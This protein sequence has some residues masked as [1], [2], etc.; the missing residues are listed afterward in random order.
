MVV[1]APCAW[2]LSVSLREPKGRI[3]AGEL[4]PLWSFSRGDRNFGSLKMNFFPATASVSSLVP[5]RESPLLAQELPAAVGDRTGVRSRVSGTRPR[6]PPEPNSP[7]G[8]EHPALRRSRGSGAGIPCGHGRAAA[9]APISAPR[10]PPLPLPVLP[11]GPGAA[12]GRAAAALGP[13]CGAGGG[14]QPGGCLPGR[15]EPGQVSPRRRAEPSCAAGLAVAPRSPGRG[16]CAGARGGRRRWAPCCWARC[17]WRLPAAPRVSA[18]PGDPALCWGT[19]GGPKR[20]DPLGRV[21]GAGPTPAGAAGAARP[22]LMAWPRLSAECLRGNGA[23]YRGN[24]RVASGGAPCLNW[25]AVRSGPGAALPAG[26]SGGRGGSGG[27]G[28][29]RRG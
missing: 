5:Y 11:A 10:R 14:A 21:R 26:G 19:K 28:G 13:G 9:A 2:S 20:G 8:T 17:C 12:R 6:V 27:L 15:E 4:S 3:R 18:A 1:S 22:A 7:R 23:S 16:C 24:R 25:L 29:G